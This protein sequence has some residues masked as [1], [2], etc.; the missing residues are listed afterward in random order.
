MPIYGYRCS[1]CN[2]ELEVWQSMSD[3]PLS[4]CPECGGKL[5]KI[6]YPV[7]VQFKGSGFYST[8]YKNGSKSGNGSTGSSSSSGSSEST[9]SESTSETKSE[10]SGS[11]TSSA[12][13][14][15]AD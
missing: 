14:S 4:T 12:S 7:G 6:L 13:D 15:K 8:D 9:K 2:H 5:E 3:T 1:Q 11:N 10:N